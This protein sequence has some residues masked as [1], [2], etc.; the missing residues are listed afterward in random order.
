MLTADDQVGQTY[1]LTG[2]ESWSL[3]ELATE[4]GSQTG[5]TIAYHD[6]PEDAYVLKQSGLPAPSAELFAN[7]D[8]G[9]SN[10]ALLD[11][12]GALSRLI[13]HPTPPLARSLADA[14]AKHR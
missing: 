4:I 14:L 8:I 6:M 3:S 13:G 7:S 11:E 5:R 1:E 9:A 2:N 12:G 10:G